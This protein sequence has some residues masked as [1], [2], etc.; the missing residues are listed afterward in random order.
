MLPYGRQEITDE[1]VETVCKALRAPMLTQGPMVGE[2]ERAIAATVGARYAVAV[3]SGTAALHAAYF[4][5]GVGP[6]VDVLTSPIT[7]VATVNAAYYLGGGAHLSDIDPDSVLIDVMRLPSTAVADRVRVITPVHFGGQ[8]A[9]MG[10]I[11]RTAAARG[12][13]VIEDAAHALGARYTVDGVEYRVGACAHSSMCCFSFHAVKHITTGEGGA[14]TTNDPSL[15][16]R[17]RQFRTH[18]ITRAETAMEAVDGP[19]YYE[20]QDLGFN[21]RLT[22]VQCALGL[23]Q[24]RRLD[25]I[26]ERRRAIAASYDALFE[27]DEHVVPTAVPPGS[28]GSYHLYVVRVPARIRRGVFERLRDAGIGVNVHYIPVHRQPYHRQRFGD[29]RFR[30]AESYYERAITLPMFPGLTDAD[31]SRVAELVASTVRRCLG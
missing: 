21:Y 23:S 7:F 15:Y 28:R 22:D 14:V 13:T 6:G 9:D 2:F 3:N 19:W 31:V 30:N 10:G 29:V 18:G 26:V 5:A 8:V 16:D 24:L 25:R 4:A 1:D 27:G 17:L 11:A 12:W 20:Q